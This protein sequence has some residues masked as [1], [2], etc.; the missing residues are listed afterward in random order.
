MSQDNI[1]RSSSLM[2]SGTM[3]SRALGFVKA[4]VL[5]TAIGVTSSVAADAFT[6]ANLLPSSVYML[7][8]GG[9][10]SSIFVPQITRALTK[11]DQGAAYINKLVT[12]STLFLLGITTVAMVAAPFLVYIYS[13]SW[14]SDERALAIAFAYWCLPQIFFYGLFNIFGEVLN[15]KKVFGPASW[16]P[17]LN[18]IIS[19]IGLVIYIAIFGSD[20]SGDQPVEDW[21]PFQIGVLGASATLGVVTQALILLVAWKKAGIRYRPDFVWRGV[22]LGKLGKIAQWSLATVVVMQL[23]GIVT[24]NVALTASGKAASIAALQYAWLIFLLPYAIFAFSIG[25]AYFTRFAEHVHNKALDKIRTDVSSA[26]RIISLVMAISG[27]VIFITAPFISTVVMAGATPTEI[28]ELAL[29]VAMYI[30]CL[31]PYGMWFV[32]QRT[33]FAFEDTRT[34]FFFTLLQVILFAAGSLLALVTTPVEL[35]AAMMALTFSVTTYIQ[36]AAALIFLSRKLQG[37]DGRRVFIS[38]LKYAIALVPTLIVGYGLWLFTIDVINEENFLLAVLE[39]VVYAIIMTAIYL[40]T[41]LL[42][43]SE[44]VRELASLL[45]RKL[46]R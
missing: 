41:L 8:V 33:Y 5:A 36:V 3:L 18:N 25:T 27:A 31:V 43:K 22:G 37:L 2:A 28:A 39:S 10:L 20:P 45:K 11:K 30:L 13:I 19:I 14:S 42:L 9:A 21:T 17:V 12:I 23:G 38:H 46:G 15:A 34:P 4:I 24:N 35:L 32:I 26:L 1:A 40:G 16:A 29:V 7:L 44:E 6:L